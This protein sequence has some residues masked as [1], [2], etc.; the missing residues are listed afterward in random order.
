[1]KILVV[2]ACALHLGFLGCYGNDWVA[3]PALDRL[4]AESVVFDQHF[5]DFPAE[6]SAMNPALV[7][8]ESLGTLKG[9]AAQATRAVERHREESQAI[10]WM[11]GPSL[12]PPWRLPKNVLAAYADE[13]AGADEQLPPLAD[14]EV[15]LTQ[16]NLDELDQ[17][18]AVYAGVVSY[19]DTQL[20]R[21]LDHLRKKKRIDEY[22]VCVTASSGLPLGEHGMTGMARAWMHEESAHIPLV[23]RLPGEE[24]AG[25]RI[26]A[27]TQP[28][29]LMPTWHEYLGVPVP[30]IRGRSLGPLVRAEDEAIRPYA[31]SG[32]RVGA[33]EEWLLRTP[34]LA[35]L[36][37]ISTPDGDPP[38]QA[39]L[40]AKPDDRWEVNDLAPRHEE[41]VQEL[42]RTLRQCV[43][44]TRAP[45]PL[46][47]PALPEEFP[48]ASEEAR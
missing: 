22:V 3:T 34:E 40:Y 13:E 14:P 28:S 30:A 44:A 16:I 43:A 25:E 11:G 27:L 18:H 33:S 10:L 21:L 20:G 1:M 32:L 29:D 5:V 6:A 2:E 38:R 23:V 35:L 7:C 41:Y 17:L 26:S 19:F 8:H 9:F 47:Y 31:V 42:D 45:G 37:P 36:V 12:A 4:A 15:G 24:K 48:V 39:R 46:D